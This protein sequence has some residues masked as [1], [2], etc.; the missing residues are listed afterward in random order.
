MRTV[1]FGG[2]LAIGLVAAARLRGCG[3]Q[4]GEDFGRP[5]F[6]QRDRDDRR[7]TNPRA[8]HEVRR[9]HPRQRQGFQA[10]LAA[11]RRAA[12]GRAQRAAD[13]DRRS[14]IWSLE[15]LRRRH[16]DALAGSHR[17][18]GIALHA[19]SFNCP[20]FADAGGTDHRPQPP[21]G[22]L[23]GHLA[24][25]PQVTR[26]TIPSSA[27]RA[28]PSARSS[29]TTAMPRRGSARTTIRP[30]FSTARPGPFDQWPSAWVSN[31]STASWAARPTSGSRTCSATHRQIFPW[32][33]KPGYNLITDMAD[34]AI[35][36]MQRAQ[37]RRSR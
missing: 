18:G 4:R 31:T 1:R 29:G 3:R 22:G 33:G 32:V 28:P 37:R 14:G 24:N 20:V 21:L 19:I 35:K 6:A 5:G 15:H 11:S 13:H 23:W 30:A 25:C 9:R 7:E 10:V 34:E 12:Q 16:P 17:Q 36:H 8:S 27:R 26:A 2:L